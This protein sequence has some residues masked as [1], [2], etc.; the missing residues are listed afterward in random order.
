MADLDTELR[1]PLQPPS[2]APAD[3]DDAFRA[4]RADVDYLGRTLGECLKELEGEA[5]FGLVERVRAL[6]KALRAAP[7]DAARRRELGRDLGGLLKSL[8]TEDA[9]RLLRAFSVYFQLI[10]LAEEVHRVRVNRLREAQAT[11]EAPRR[12]SVAAA[13]K[14]LRDDGW[15]ASEVRRF[16]EG[17]DIQPTLTAHPTEVKRYTVRLK[18][19][20]I[21]SRLRARTELELSPQARRRLEGE[22]AAEVA[23]LW[24]TRELTSEK[25]SVTD[26]VKAALYYFQRSLLSAV[27]QL[28]Q[29]LEDALES[30]YGCARGE[31]PL[32]PVVRF[33][34]WIGG[35]RDGNPFVTPEVTE[36]AY[37]LQ[38]EVAFGQHLADLDGLVQR[39]SQWGGRTRISPELARELAAL[40]ADRRPRRFAG[41]PYRLKLAV[42]YADLRRAHE[43]LGR[44]DLPA[45]VAERY[46]EDLR[47]VEE[48][49]WAGGE[50]RVAEA[51]VRPVRYRA[52]A[53]GVHLAAL[54]LREHSSLHEAAVADLLRYA[55]VCDDYAA[56]DE[57]ARVALLAREL[58][59]KRPLA[60]EDAPLEEETGRALGFLRVLRRLRARYGP[61]AVG[62]Y[63]VSMTAGVSDVLEP[64][65]LA[66]E[67]G[68]PDLDVTPLFETLADLRAAPRI[69]QE[70]FALPVYLEHVRRRGIQEV[71]IGY[72]DS[73]K[74][75]GFLAANWALYEAQERV[76][77]VCREV[78]VPL[79][80]FHGRGTSIGR[81]GG[82]AGRAILAQPP[83]TLGGRMRLTEQGE[84]L[85]ERYTDP[86]LAHRHLEQ[87]AHAFILSSA[88]GARGD[89]PEPPVRYREAMTRAAE[90]ARARY[91]A[92]LEAD[93]FLDFYHTVTPI[94]EISRLNIGSRPARRKGERSLA[95]L[96]AIPWVFSWTQ[97]R[98][99]LPGWFGLGTGLSSVDGALL[100]EMYRE[101]S[102][103]RT[104]LDFAQMSLAKADLG[105][106]T[107]YLTLVPDALRERFWPLIEREYRLS[108]ERVTAATGQ[109][110]LASD[111]TLARGIELRNPYV[112][113]ISYVQVELLRRL[114]SLPEGAPERGGLEEAVM[115]SLLGVATGLRNTG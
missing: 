53:F 66:K 1:P 105:I 80:L 19:E 81:G 3:A 47:T 95:N 65:L 103:F 52:A 88:R 99:N 32:P 68:I 43:A 91:R 108:V 38:S 72:S 86:D 79:R 102:F 70:L 63:I 67:A 44:G 98:A 41:E 84:A 42:T 14:A 10:N 20:R 28:M 71:M 24:R 9:E 113:P 18:L 26:E 46:L 110:L 56:Q 82:P 25:P 40:P 51:F 31:A 87:L 114:R 69:L 94:E 27:P 39:L 96:R 73:N 15:S 50:G 92:L 13:V 7:E 76:A 33:R 49:L 21:A 59:S 90:G 57:A 83:G 16:I 64:L 29:D 35:D 5:F 106:F 77:A 6:T 107:A 104:I 12:E 75:A 55:G 115:I 2:G 61:A 78:G 36:E 37:A 22:L 93:G 34:S 4:L 109:P 45:G 112:D 23:S 8:T 97:C 85:S 54:D 60:P 48:S 17:L 89:L 100:R 111:P 74:D 62:S 11:P 58:R 30:L 101:W